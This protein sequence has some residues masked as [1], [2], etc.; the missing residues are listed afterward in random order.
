M[1]DLGPCWITR[2]R[3]WVVGTSRC[4][5]A[6]R[7]R[8][9]GHRLAGFLFASRHHPPRFPPLLPFTD[10]ELRS[11]SVPVVVVVG[12]K[13]EMLDAKLIVDRTRALIPTSETFM[14]AGA[15]HA[16][17]VSHFDDCLAPLLHH[18]DGATAG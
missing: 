10:A 17:T 11:I 14:V 5:P 16:L 18:C 4:Q 6:G 9:A 7:T 15:G 2:T 12:E 3:R 8:T 13:S 1:S